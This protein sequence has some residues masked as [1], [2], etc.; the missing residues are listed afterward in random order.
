M[1]G[2]LEDVNQ[3]YL[4]DGLWTAPD[5]F[6]MHCRWLETCLEDTYVLKFAEDRIEITASNNSPW[7]MM[8][9]EPVVAELVK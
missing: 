9:Q 8:G 6:E 1:L 3:L 4:C 7:K 5:T 2:S